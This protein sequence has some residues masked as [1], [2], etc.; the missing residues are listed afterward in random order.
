MSE[1]KIINAASS[2]LVVLDYGQYYI[3]FMLFSPFA[4]PVYIL[5]L[6]LL[7]GSEI[8]WGL[9]FSF[10]SLG[11]TPLFGKCARRYKTQSANLTD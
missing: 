3:N 5:V 2:D 6:W 7:G 11:V 10:C 9:L 4:L 8:I 1:G